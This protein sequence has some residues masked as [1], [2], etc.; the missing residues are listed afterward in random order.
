MRDRVDFDT[1]GFE[2]GQPENRL[3]VV[4]AET[5][6]GPDDLAHELHFGYGD[7]DRLLAPIRKF[8]SSPSPWL[9]ADFSQS[10]PGND[11]VGRAGVDQKQ[12]VPATLGLGGIANGDG[13]LDDAHEGFLSLKMAREL[14]AMDSIGAR[15][16]GKCSMR[17]HS[18]QGSRASYLVSLSASSARK[19]SVSEEMAAM[20]LR[21]TSMARAKSP[22]SA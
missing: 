17:R 8:I 19:L 18:R 12:S 10:A 1:D 3:D 6:G 21:W 15:S 9:Y 4:V 22:F 11:A 14:Y 20:A 13:D 5:D 16:K 7:I 2:C